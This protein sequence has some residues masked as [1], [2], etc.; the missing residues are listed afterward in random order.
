MSTIVCESLSYRPVSSN[1]GKPSTS[2][3]AVVGSVKSSSLVTPVP[4]SAAQ[5]WPSSGAATEDSNV[6][7]R[8]FGSAAFI[9]V[10][11]LG[12]PPDPT[13]SPRILVDQVSNGDFVNVSVPRGSIIRAIATTIA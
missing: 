13:A 2:D 3:V 7:V 1:L 10:G 12:T 6:R 8:C 4:A 5:V 9:A 11:P